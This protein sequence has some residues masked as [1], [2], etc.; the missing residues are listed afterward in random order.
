MCITD[1]FANQRVVSINAQ[2]KTRHLK[3]LMDN[4]IHLRKLTAFKSRCVLKYFEGTN[5][6][7]I[8]IVEN[9]DLI[10]HYH[11]F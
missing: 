11:H 4:S 5:N 2:P 1:Y 10:L 7:Q 9:E 3:M 6:K 8:E